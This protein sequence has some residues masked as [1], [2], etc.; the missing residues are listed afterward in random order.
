MGFLDT[1]KKW[2]GS[3]KEKAEE[4]APKAW[5][6]TKD[7]AAKTGDVA[8]KAWEKTKDVAGDLKDRFGEDKGVDTTDTTDT[9]GPM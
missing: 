6:K 2:F 9:S 8:E 3:S 5:E 1:L 7:V 4:V